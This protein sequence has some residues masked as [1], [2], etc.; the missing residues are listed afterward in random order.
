MWRGE[1]KTSSGFR[2][3]PS[4]TVANSASMPMAGSPPRPVEV[5]PHRAALAMRSLRRSRFCTITPR[6]LRELAPPS[7][8]LPR[9]RSQRISGELEVVGLAGRLTRHRDH[10]PE[11]EVEVV[12]RVLVRRTKRT[13]PGSWEYLAHE[14]SVLRDRVVRVEV[15]VP[16]PVHIRRGPPAMGGRATRA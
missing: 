9:R 12:V 5:D 2:G 11:V 3:M 8:P 1:P 16:H 6:L 7:R 13:R 10:I 4:I 15:C 14:G